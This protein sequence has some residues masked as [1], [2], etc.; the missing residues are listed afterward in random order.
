MKERVALWD[1]IKFILITLVVI[2]HLADEF[3]NKSGVYRS[4]FLFVYAFHMPL[5]IFVS[6]LFH[7][8]KNIVKKS[9]FYISIGFLYKIVTVITDIFQGNKNISFSFLSDG[10]VSWFMFVL[11]TY[12]VLLYIIRN[13]NKKYILFSSIIL[14]L[15]IGYDSSI[16]DFLYL[17]R[18]I[19]FFPFYLLGTM[20]KSEDIINFKKKYKFIYI[21]SIFIFVLWLVLCFCKID[22]LYKLRYLFTGR[23]AFYEPIIKYGPLARLFCYT[24]STLLCISVII[25]TPSKQIKFITDMG[26]NS[27]NVYFWH[28][29]IYIILEKLFYISSLFYFGVF[30]KITFL[31]IAVIIS[32]ILSQLKIFD[33]PTKQIKKYC[34]S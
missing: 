21:F 7:N 33:F 15:F 8:E 30:G 4:I 11:A 24:V 25:L 31:F 9:I 34:F 23:N 27:I 22:L 19:I 2:G 6:G 14:A 28:W 13:E 3:T 29:K 16:G 32:I 26:K 20:I 18:T 5:F 10:G 17:S 1:N 12:T